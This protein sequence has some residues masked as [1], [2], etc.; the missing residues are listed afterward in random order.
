VRFGSATEDVGLEICWRC[1]DGHAGHILK[2]CLSLV[3]IWIGS[4]FLADHSE[5][6][7]HVAS[8][9]SDPSTQA[10]LPSLTGVLKKPVSGVLASFRPSTY[11]KGTPRIF[12]RCGLVWDKARLGV[13][14]LGG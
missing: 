12:T 14:G 13:P 7:H 8:D 10:A 2:R 1:I 3:F 4:P 6:F 5:Q 11:P 9:G